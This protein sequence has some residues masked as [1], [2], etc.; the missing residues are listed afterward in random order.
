MGLSGHIRSER[1]RQT[2]PEVLQGTHQDD[3]QGAPGRNGKKNRRVS[4]RRRKHRQRN[5]PASKRSGRSLVTP[6]SQRHCSQRLFLS[7]LISTNLHRPESRLPTQ[8]IWTPIESTSP[9]PLETCR[10]IRSHRTLCRTTINGSRKAAVVRTGKMA[11][12]P[13]RP[14]KIITCY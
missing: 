11:D 4:R 8:A 2:V 6:L 14:F 1:G 10:F 5:P 13:Q 9:K 3:L 7:G 12:C